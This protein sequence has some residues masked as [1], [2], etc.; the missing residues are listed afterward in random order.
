[1]ELKN[2]LSRFAE[3]VCEEYLTE[4]GRK[5]LAKAVSHFNDGDLSDYFVIKVEGYNCIAHT[6]D[7]FTPYEL[8]EHIFPYD[9][10]KVYPMQGLVT[11]Y[12][13]KRY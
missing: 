9:D 10:E 11:E 8:D 2:Y 1:M 7:D 6:S 13:F 4:N 5:A 3:S 12:G